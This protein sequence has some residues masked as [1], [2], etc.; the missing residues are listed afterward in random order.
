M[1]AFTG[2][3][4]PRTGA[5]YLE[6][7]NTNAVIEPLWRIFF[8]LTDL[9]KPCQDWDVQPLFYNTVLLCV[10]AGSML[11]RS[12]FSEEPLALDVT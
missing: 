8:V 10:A 2:S 4:I 7:S 5:I 1:F 11:N 9:I 3:G 12:S 6:P